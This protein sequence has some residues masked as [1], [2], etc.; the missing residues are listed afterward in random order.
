MSK[1]LNAE[2]HSVQEVNTQYPCA[3]SAIFAPKSAWILRD[4]Y[5]GK[6]NHEPN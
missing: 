4:A 3:F 5:C 6:V 2:Y 1:K